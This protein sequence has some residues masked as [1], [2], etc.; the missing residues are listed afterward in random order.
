MEHRPIDDAAMLRRFGKAVGEARRRGH[1]TVADLASRLGLDARMLALLE[2]GSPDAARRLTLRQIF[3][4][5]HHLELD[6]E[7]LL[8]GLAPQA[9][10]PAEPAGQPRQPVRVLA[11]CRLR[12]L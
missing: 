2:H 10:P 4:L 5:E 3:A 11:S 7:Q 12:K 1:W 6:L 8:S 9:G